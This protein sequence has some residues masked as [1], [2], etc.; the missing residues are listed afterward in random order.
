MRSPMQVLRDLRLPSGER[1]EAKKQR[2]AE[3]HAREAERMA[4]RTEAESRRHGEGYGGYSG[5]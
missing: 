4:A 2:D 1:R 3:K 5:R